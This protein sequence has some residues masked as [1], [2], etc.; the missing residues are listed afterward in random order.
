MSVIKYFRIAVVRA[1][2]ILGEVE[3]AV[4]LWRDIG[5]ELG[6]SK[7]ELDQFADAFEHPERAAVRRAIG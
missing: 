7:P 2:E 4:T 6:L 5:R 1:K 3:A